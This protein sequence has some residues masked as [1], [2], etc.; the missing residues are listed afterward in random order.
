VAI[1]DDTAAEVSWQYED[2]AHYTDC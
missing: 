2:A 1:P